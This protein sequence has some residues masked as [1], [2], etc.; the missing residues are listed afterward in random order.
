MN[1]EDNTVQI[2]PRLEFRLNSIDSNYSSTDQCVVASDPDIVDCDDNG[3]LY[4]NIQH[5]HQDAP[6]HHLHSL[7]HI[8][9]TSFPI[10]SLTQQHLAIDDPN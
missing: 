10:L 8:P 3:Q 6:R 4:E 2:L 9:K 7:H 5:Q 1:S